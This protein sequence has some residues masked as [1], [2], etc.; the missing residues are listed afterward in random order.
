MLGETARK[1]ACVGCILPIIYSVSC[2]NDRVL[3]KFMFSAPSSGSQLSGYWS[4][5]SSCSGV[6][7]H[8]SSSHRTGCPKK[9][10]FC[11]WKTAKKN[12]VKHA[13]LL[14]NWQYLE[15]TFF[16]TPCSHGTREL[17]KTSTPAWGRRL[18]E[19][20]KW[21]TLIASQES[22]ISFIVVM[23]LAQPL[24]QI[25]NLSVWCRVSCSSLNPS[26]STD[27]IPGQP[28]LHIS[29]QKLHFFSAEN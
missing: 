2:N 15:T 23:R 13:Y 25:H 4:P 3:M 6:W 12:K 10:V 28:T 26:V 7:C 20:H 5:E 24:E 1:R 8:M 14:E 11:V 16:W 22:G 18:R 19:W 21:E 9:S 29:S 17:N 27:L